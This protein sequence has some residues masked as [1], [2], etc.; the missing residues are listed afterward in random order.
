MPSIREFAFRNEPVHSTRI[1]RYKLRSCLLSSWLHCG[2]V[3]LFFSQNLWD[4]IK[5]EVKKGVVYSE[6]HTGAAPHHSFLL[7]LQIFMR[8]LC[9][10]RK[11]FVKLFFSVRLLFR[12][13]L[14]NCNNL[15]MKLISVKTPI[16]LGEKRH[17]NILGGRVGLRFLCCKI[18][19]GRG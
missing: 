16:S 13:L 11:K 6:L 19:E 9:T 5:K 18:L 2:L 14:Q 8:P 1:T 12:N 3:F 4:F 15:L 7:V 10:N 17:R